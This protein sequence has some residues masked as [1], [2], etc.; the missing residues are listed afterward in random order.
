MPYHRQYRKALSDTFDIYL[1]ILQRVDGYVNKLLRRDSHDWRVQN[2]C[3]ACCYEVLVHRILTIGRHTDYYTPVKGE[4]LY[5]ISSHVCNGWE[6]LP[7]TYPTGRLP[8]N[9]RSPCVRKRLFSV[10]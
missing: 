3:P 1:T 2:S 6:Q 5:A 4:A 9:C 7:E 8:C 10:T